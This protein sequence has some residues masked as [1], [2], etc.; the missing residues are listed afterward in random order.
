[1][2]TIVVKTDNKGLQLTSRFSKIFKG[3]GKK[4]ALNQKCKRPENKTQIYSTVWCGTRGNRKEG[5]S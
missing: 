1:M 3:L 5:D 2:V 4:A